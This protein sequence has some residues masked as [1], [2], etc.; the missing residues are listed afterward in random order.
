[1]KKTL[2]AMAAVAV[3]GAASAQVSITGAVG[4]GYAKDAD[5]KGYK[6]TD[7][8]IVFSATEDLGGGLSVKA[9]TKLDSL[10][11]RGTTNPTNADATI[12]VVN[13]DLTVTAGSFEAA[14]DAR[15][16]DVSGI[17][18]EK[19]L[20][21]TAYN[22]GSVNVD[23]ISASLKLNGELTLGV[24]HT[25]SGAIGDANATNKT[26]KV[27]ATYSSGPLMVYVSQANYTVA[28]YPSKTE[29]AVTY[30][31]GVAK[32]GVGSANKGGA[33]TDNAT[34][35]SISV[36]MGAATFGAARASSGS[37]KG[38]V[39]GVNYSLSKQTTLYVSR[40]TSNQTALDASY[41]VKLVK[42]F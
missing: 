16:G 21:Q 14:A 15:K 3:A 25:E 37:A 22:L 20:D 18:L 4:F 23:G 10:L 31:M 27:A 42:A 1:M 19:G 38:T 26:T 5:A 6:M 24:S 39:Y 35:A 17:S 32:L 40:Q 41:R 36:P 8:N 29:M 7:G 34:I 28:T 9:S 11:G 2:I 30:D 33:N 12:T 13:G